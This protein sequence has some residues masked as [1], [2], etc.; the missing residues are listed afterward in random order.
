MATIVN[1]DAKI[2]YKKSRRRTVITLRS[3]RAPVYNPEI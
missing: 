2:V 3:V 1:I